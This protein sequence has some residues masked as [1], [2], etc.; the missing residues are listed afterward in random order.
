MKPFGMDVP[1]LADQLGCRTTVRLETRSQRMF[2]C[3]FAVFDPAIISMII[4]FIGWNALRKV[5]PFFGFGCTK[6]KAT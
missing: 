4:T 5:R 6:T 3:N 1:F 2:L